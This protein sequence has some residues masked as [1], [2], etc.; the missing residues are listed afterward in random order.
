MPFHATQTRSRIVVCVSTGIGKSLRAK[1][2][3]RLLCEGWILDSGGGSNLEGKNGGMERTCGVMLYY[4]GEHRPF[5][6][7]PLSV[8]LLTYTTNERLQRS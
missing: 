2:L 4:D 8:C 7:H 5:V 6:L 1:R 3:K